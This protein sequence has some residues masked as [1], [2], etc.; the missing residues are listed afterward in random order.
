M[1]TE[2]GLLAQCH[3]T[4]GRVG[5][6]S[7]HSNFYLF[8][9]Y[10]LA[11]WELRA[12]LHW[13]IKFCFCAKAAPSAS[14]AA[15]HLCHAQAC[16][17]R[18]SDILSTSACAGPGLS[19][20]STGALLCALP[21]SPPA[22]LWTAVLSMG[23]VSGALWGLRIPV[24]SMGVLPLTLVGLNFIHKAL[25]VTIDFPAPQAAHAEVW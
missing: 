12:K 25:P 14:S 8:V 4:P 20:G 6:L 21:S 2:G 5:H 1:T 3:G 11:L 19:W 24:K 9:T 13:P 18:Q 10:A 23:E 16:R 15:R 17:Y 22:E 7:S